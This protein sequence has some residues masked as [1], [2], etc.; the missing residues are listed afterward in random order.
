MTEEDDHARQSEQADT[1]QPASE[2]TMDVISPELQSAVEK[3]DEKKPGTMTEFLAMGMGSVGNPLHHKMTTEHISQVLNL[4]AKH[5]ER[6]YE[7]QKQSQSDDFSEGKSNRAYGFAVFVVVII[8]ILIVLFLFQDKPDVLVP[9]ITGLVGLVS[10]FLG[11]WG[12]G[13]K[14]K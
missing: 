4:T 14:Q 5:D 7:L 12:L 11:G 1:D 9:I 3:L 2:N 13:S 6:E 8:V 10:G